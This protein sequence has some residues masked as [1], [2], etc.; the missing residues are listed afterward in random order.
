MNGFG[1]EERLVI[2]TDSVGWVHPDCLQTCACSGLVFLCLLHTQLFLS[3]GPSGICME[4]VA[5]VL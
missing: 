4:Q 1:A 3:P 5:E 2:T